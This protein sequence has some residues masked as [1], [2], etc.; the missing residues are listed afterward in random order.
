MREEWW[1]ALV[2]PAL[3][4]TFR[5]TPEHLHAEVKTEDGSIIDLVHMDRQQVTGFE[6]KVATPG[7]VLQPL[8]A[9]ALRQ[10]RHFRQACNAVYLVTLAA[11]RSLELNAE[12]R[13]LVH[14]PLEAQLLPDG[15]GWA[16][17][18]RL[19]HEVIVLRQAP[20]LEPK[21]SAR[22]FIINQLTSRLGRA[23]RAVEGCRI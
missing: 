1:Q 9:R 15:V 6:L 11:P 12:G 22:S 18:D 2:A 23:R 13:V 19:S 3:C 8:N 21:R 17:F 14:E 7:E 5:L 10:L 16:V 4:R 20:R